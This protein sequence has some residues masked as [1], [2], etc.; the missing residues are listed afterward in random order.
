MEVSA[1]QLEKARD[2]WGALMRGLAADMDLGPEELVPRVEAAAIRLAVREAQQALRA[3]LE[4]AV[5]L[6]GPDSE[7][8]SR[9]RQALGVL[10][11]IA[12]EAVASSEL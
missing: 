9:L 10:E 6:P 1:A 7:L 11:A 12:W 2:R 8:S 3:A 5:A 4:S